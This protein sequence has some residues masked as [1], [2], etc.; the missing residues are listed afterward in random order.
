MSSAL[1]HPYG[2]SDCSLDSELVQQNSH[3]SYVEEDIVLAGI[4]DI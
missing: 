1:R 3:L 4:C 2:K